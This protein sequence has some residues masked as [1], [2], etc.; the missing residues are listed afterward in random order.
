MILI[1]ITGCFD[2]LHDGHKRL[3]KRAFTISDCMVNIS[4]DS[5]EKILREKGKLNQ[6]WL[7]R[8]KTVIEYCETFDKVFSVNFHNSNAELFENLKNNSNLNYKIKI[9][10]SDYLKKEIVGA[11]LFDEIIFLKR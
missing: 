3:L 4:I 1:F 5:D 8:E 11:E 7:Q 2:P 10:G 6:D 9:L